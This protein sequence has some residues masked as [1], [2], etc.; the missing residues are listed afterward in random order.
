M[1]KKSIDIKD[2]GIGGLT[3]EFLTIFRKVFASRLLANNIKEELGINHVRG[4][5]LYG[6]PGCGKTAL[7]RQLGKLLNCIEPKIVNGPSLLNKYVGESEENTRKL[8]A[9]AIADKKK[10]N[11]NNLHLIICDEFDAIGKK[12]G[13]VSSSTGVS[14]QVVNTFLTM[15]DGVNSLDN[16]LLICM[17]NRKDMIDE[18][19][20]RYGRLEVHIEIKLPTKEGRVEILNIHTNKMKLSNRFDENIDLIEIANNTQNYSGAELEGLVRTAT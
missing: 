10:G 5:L 16:I 8:F 1:F 3:D 18:A 14:E 11:N 19:L 15:I 9:D 2:L 7:A 20:L 6:P 4:V 13:S 17:T 12:R